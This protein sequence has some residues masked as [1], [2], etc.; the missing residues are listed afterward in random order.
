M[1][2]DGKHVVE[3]FLAL[4]VASEPHTAKNDKSI[5]ASR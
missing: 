2:D 1:A 4:G 3:Q 5:S